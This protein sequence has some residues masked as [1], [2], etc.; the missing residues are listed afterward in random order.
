M[1]YWFTIEPYVY[2]NI[3]DG[4]TGLLYN[5]LDGEYIEFEDKIIV[6]FLEGIY[7]E[8]NCGVL[9]LS[10]EMYRN[11]Q[12]NNFLKDVREKYMGDI[13]STSESSG[14][15]I[16]ILP[17]VNFHCSLKNR[18]EYVLFNMDNLLQTLL[19]VNLHINHESNLNLLSQFLESIPE[20]VRLNIFYEEE[21]VDIDSFLSFSLQRFKD[22]NITLLY[23]SLN[24]CEI[25][26]SNFR[27]RIAIKFPVDQSV[28]DFVLKT[29]K[30]LYKRFIFNISSLDDFQKAEELISRYNIDDYVISPIYTG[31]NV[32]F[33]KEYIYLKRED[34][35]SEVISMRTIFQRHIININYF[36]KIHVLPNGDVCAN[37]HNSVIGNICKNG[38]YEIINKEIREGQ[39]WLRVRDKNPCNRCLYQYICPSPS[40]I[41][42]AIG[43]E[44]LCLIKK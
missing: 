3:V 21:K 37:I 31:D 17:Y 1:D 13:I 11:E 39:S 43:K 10:E 9:F 15:P 8:E 19:E 12:L 23:S 14:K 16:Q 41:E 27:Y 32:D 6:N 35:F 24:N 22:I 33:F 2:L 38:I 20:S 25:V 4:E 28:L 18:S 7:S 29:T 36:G 30:D 26:S 42:L 44:N 40:D 34:L 5:T